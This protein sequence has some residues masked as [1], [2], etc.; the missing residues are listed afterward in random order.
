[1]PLLSVVERRELTRK[2]T[3]LDRHTDQ[4]REEH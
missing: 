1:L 2:L 4:L 3:A